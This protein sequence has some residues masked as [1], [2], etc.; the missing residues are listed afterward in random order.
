MSDKKGQKNDEEEEREGTLDADALND[1]FDEQGF[2]D[3]DE[4]IPVIVDPENTE[5]ED[6]DAEWNS[7]DDNKDW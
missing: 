7:Y 6:D 1:A 5:K 3:E 2:G 4:V